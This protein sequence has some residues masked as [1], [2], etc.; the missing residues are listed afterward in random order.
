MRMN[1][2]Q[3]RKNISPSPLTGEGWGEGENVIPPPLHPV[4]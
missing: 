1:I 2:D 3:N 4:R